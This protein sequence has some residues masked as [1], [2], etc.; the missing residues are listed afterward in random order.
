MSMGCNR[1]VF[2]AFI[3]ALSVGVLSAQ[4]AVTDANEADAAEE[5]TTLR[6]DGDQIKEYI[7]WLAQDEREGRRSLTTGYDE[8]VDWAVEHFADLGLAPAGENGTYLQEVPIERGFVYRT[9]TPELAVGNRVFLP[10]EGD[11]TPYD[12]STPATSV[13]AEVVFVGYGIAAPEKGLDEYAGLDV[14]GKIVLAL[15]GSPKNAAAPRL[16]FGPD[17]PEVE[18]TEAWEEE[19]KDQNKIR[20]AYDLGAAAILLYEA[21]NPEEPQRMRW[22]QGREESELEPDRDFLAFTISERVFRAIMKPDRQESVAGFNRRMDQWRFDIRNETPHSAATGV[23][24]ELK[25]YDNVQEY[26]EDLENNIS[27]NVLA[28]IE[29][30]DPELKNEFII[31]G[32]HMDHLGVRNGLIYN[33]ADDN[34]SGTAVVLEVARVLAEADYQPKRTIIFCC[35]CAE[36]LGLI[37]SYYYTAHPCDGVTLDQVVT[38][39]NLDMVG[40]GDTIGAP[41]ALNF[42]SIWEVITKNQDEDVLDALAPSTTGPG[43]S[44]YSGFISRGIEALALM[45]EGGSGHPDYHQPEDD[46]EKMDPE[47]LRKTGQFTLQAVINLDRETEVDLLIDNRQA[48]YNGMR[49]VVT[50]IDPSVED[51]DWTCVDLGADTYE[52]LR[53]AVASVRETPEKGIETGIRDLRPFDGDVELLLA[54]CQGWGAGRVDLSGSDGTWVVKGR[55][56]EDGRYLLGMLERRQIVCNLVNPSPALLRDVLLATRRPFIVTG[57]Y[58]LD[59]LTYD[60]IN[61]RNILLAVEFDPARVDDCAERLQTVRTALGDTDNLVL[62]VTSNYN[63]DEAKQALYLKL[64]EQGWEPEEIGNDRAA[65]PRGRRDRGISGHN[66]NALLQ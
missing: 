50:K 62:S 33:G 51:S 30:T 17:L 38:Y 12:L 53:A 39:I 43:G 8:A 48:I 11:F 23:Q 32:G 61:K 59:P 35:W 40:L 2:M 26:S 20:T 60:T 66:L 49:L 1:I 45:T 37:G 22:R 18:Q 9:G 6:V 63:L 5:A 54:A 58:L 55:L 4:E 65:N 42:P 28:K 41:G 44:D 64:I 7:T 57:F 13:E 21:P 19:A 29:G 14:S 27:H 46:P 15:K 34:A 16:R 47:I 31:I 3:M 24:A 52:K 10:E 25:G 36:E 56:T